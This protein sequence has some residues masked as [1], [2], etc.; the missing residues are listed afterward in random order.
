MT[1]RQLGETSLE[2]AADH[3]FIEAMRLMSEACMQRRSATHFRGS[4]RLRSE[5]KADEFRATAF[6]LAVVGIDAPAGGQS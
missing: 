2:R 4:D 6:A 3:S 1:D 5:A